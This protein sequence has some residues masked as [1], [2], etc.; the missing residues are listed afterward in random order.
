VHY[1]LHPDNARSLLDRLNR[2]LHPAEF[3]RRGEGVSL[4]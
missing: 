2:V 3:D 1:S 4:S